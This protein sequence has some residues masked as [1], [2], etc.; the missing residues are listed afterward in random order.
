MI[1]VLHCTDHWFCHLV[2]TAQFPALFI[3]GNCSKKRSCNAYLSQ[4][5]RGVRSLL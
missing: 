2:Y 1:N 4:S 5:T 3:C